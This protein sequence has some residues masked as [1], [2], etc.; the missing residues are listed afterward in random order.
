MT[1]LLVFHGS[2]QAGWNPCAS[3]N[4]SCSHLC[5][6]L[7]GENESISNS[8]K[9]ECPTHYNLA[10]DNKTCIGWYKFIKF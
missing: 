7:P 9:C 6:A 5:I 10:E 3:K 4:G 1:D 2:R 8:F